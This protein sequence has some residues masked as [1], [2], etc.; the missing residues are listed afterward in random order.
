MSVRQQLEEIRARQLIYPLQGKLV[1]QSNLTTLYPRIDQSKLC[2][3]L[4][5][6]LCAWDSAIE[7]YLHEC[8]E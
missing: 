6:S 5:D 2:R 1:L 8:L 4:A 7:D 3:L